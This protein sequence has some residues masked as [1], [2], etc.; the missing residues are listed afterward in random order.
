MFFCFLATDVILK[1][2][3]IKLFHW[4]YFMLKSLPGSTENRPPS[5]GGTPKTRRRWLR[6]SRMVGAALW[7]PED[8][9]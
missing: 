8:S 2:E 6:E 5:F 9:R 1:T 4:K 3:Q 7:S